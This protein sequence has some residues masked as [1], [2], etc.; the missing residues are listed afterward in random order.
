MPRLTKAQLLNLL[1]VGD[2]K[3]KRLSEELAKT[4]SER[5]AL[6]RSATVAA[7]QGLIERNRFE[8][9]RFAALHRDYTNE[10]VFHSD[11]KN[12]LYARQKNL[13]DVITTIQTLL[14]RGKPTARAVV[15]EVIE[16]AL[17]KFK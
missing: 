4:R 16:R 11:V 17:E 6:Q 3:I 1:D 10:R 5:D 13:Y 7:V 9:D 2:S 12:A 15:L 14:K 8:S